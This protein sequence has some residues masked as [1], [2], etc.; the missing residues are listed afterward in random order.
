MSI[1]ITCAAAFKFTRDEKWIN[2]SRKC[3]S[4]FLG[5]N[6]LGIQIYNYQTGG[7]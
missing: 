3:F 7:C 4:W 1:I 2:K 6:D 5:L